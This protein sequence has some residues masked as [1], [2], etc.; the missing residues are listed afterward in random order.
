MPTIKD[1]TKKEVPA[2]DL[3]ICDATRQMI[4]KGRRD[5]V[6]NRF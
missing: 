6:E 2:S 5:G 4:E 1:D 3:T